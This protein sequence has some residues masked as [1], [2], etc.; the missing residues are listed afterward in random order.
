[1]AMI[2]VYFDIVN[3]FKVYKC[4]DFLFSNEKKYIKPK[5]IVIIP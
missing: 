3:Y 2:F 5:I 1:M 4:F